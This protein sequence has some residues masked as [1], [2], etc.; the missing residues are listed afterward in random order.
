MPAL[1]N[2]EINLLNTSCW[3]NHFAI[4][5]FSGL[6]G[7]TSSSYFHKIVNGNFSNTFI[8]VFFTSEE[9][10]LDFALLPMLK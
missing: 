6:P 7:S 3:G 1:T 4:L 8:N 9:K 5:T 10:S 2:D